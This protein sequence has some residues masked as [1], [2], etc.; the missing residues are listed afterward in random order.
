MDVGSHE[1][2]RGEVFPQKCKAEIEKD[3]RE[4]RVEME[5]LAFNMQQETKVCWRYEWPLKR[6][7]R[8]FVRDFLARGKQ[9]VLKIWLRYDENLS[10]EGKRFGKVS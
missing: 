8:W 7:T 2:G 4:I 9:H 1:H 10:E 6:K 3:L 5:E